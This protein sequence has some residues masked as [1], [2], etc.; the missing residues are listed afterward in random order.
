MIL[1]PEAVA[2]F[3]AFPSRNIVR[4]SN[5]D[6]HDLY[7]AASRQSAAV[8]AAVI[9]LSVAHF[10]NWDHRARPSC[11]FKQLAPQQGQDDA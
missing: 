8:D 2:P 10:G 1:Q 6:I 9:C 7:S 3:A 5:V 11:Q 4:P